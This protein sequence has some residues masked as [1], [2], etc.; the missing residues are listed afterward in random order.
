MPFLAD[1]QEIVAALP[2]GAFGGVTGG[3]D[4]W[5]QFIG[6]LHEPQ[7]HPAA[8]YVVVARVLAE[9]M[10]SMSP[11][12][13]AEE[14][15]RQMIL[16][17]VKPGSQPFAAD[18]GGPHKDVRPTPAHVSC[19]L[20]AQVRA[21]QQAGTAPASFPGA[22]A[23]LSDVMAQHVRAQEEVLE[24]D[25]KRG[26]L[27]YSLSTRLQEMGLTTLPEEAKPS[28]ESLLRVE[29]LARVARNEG[30][31]WIGSAEGEDL[32]VNFRPS[33]TKTP[34]LDA[35]AGGGSIDEKARE[36]AA[37][38]KLRALHDKVDFMSFANF[39]GHLLDWGIK[40][41]V[42]KAISPIDLLS[43]QLILCR[44]SEEFGGVRAAYYYDV[45]QRQKLAKALQNTPSLDVSLFLN[46]MDHDTLND[47]QAK[48]DSKAKETGRDIARQQGGS[49][50]GGPRSQ[51]MQEES[52]R[53]TPPSF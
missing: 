32:Q 16:D 18:A 19:A 5:L 2:Q 17:A 24:K 13:Y 40:M 49:G 36:S 12:D 50:K 37:S 38:K 4:A 21:R 1:A 48:Y 31:K 53:D 15:M 41:I 46:K 39:T 30:R 42:T 52:A 26:T 8:F 7:T 28:E 33:W 27:P 23:N 44:V 3:L 51:A 22:P 25:K 14:H 29:A 34:A 10:G 9:Q 6:A 11:Q 20:M 35:F 43:Y 45:L 47:A